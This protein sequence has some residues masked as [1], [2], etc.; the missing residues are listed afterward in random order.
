MWL[1]G[2]AVLVIVV[3]AWKGAAKGAVWQLAVLGSI[4]A[5]IFV[6]GEATPY[7]EQEIP[8]AQPLK[9]WVALGAVYAVISLVVFIL[10]R[11]IR[12]WLERIRF[13]E[14]DRHWGAILGAMKG[15]ILVLCV[16]CL[17][18]IMAPSTHAMIRESVT[19]TITN[20]TIQ[21]AAPMLPARLV[22]A[23]QKAIDSS[24]N[25]SISSPSGD[26]FQLSL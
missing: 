15:A 6:A 24:G 20:Q 5:C 25:S 26:T 8:L 7:V 1:D 10:A 23:L 19:G 14:Y 11:A 18:L 22:D 4:A 3:A 16:T 2:C 12:G 21:Y 9:H 13:V 17:M